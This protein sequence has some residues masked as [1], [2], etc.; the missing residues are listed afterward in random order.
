VKVTA[1]TPPFLTILYLFLTY[2][3]SIMGYIVKI[4]YKLVNFT[5]TL[6]Y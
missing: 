2:N 3:T 1:Y 4:T 6:P 5:L